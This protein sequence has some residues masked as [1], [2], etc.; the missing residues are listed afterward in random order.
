MTMDLVGYT[1]RTKAIACIHRCERCGK[2]CSNLARFEKEKDKRFKYLEPVP[3]QPSVWYEHSFDH[4]SSCRGNEWRL[5]CR[6]RIWSR[7][8]YCRAIFLQANGKTGNH[9]KEKCPAWR[10]HCDTLSDDAFIE[11][12]CD[13]LFDDVFAEWLCDTLFGYASVEGGAF[14]PFFVIYI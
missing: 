12:I 13:G 11:E 9:S 6:G 4:K 1:H 7:C 14:L 5:D 2:Q 10:E 8:E 3:E